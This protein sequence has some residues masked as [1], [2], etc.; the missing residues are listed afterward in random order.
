MK[1]YP[2]IIGI[3]LIGAVIC[4]CSYQTVA[5]A[6]YLPQ[7][8]YMPAAVNGI[9]TI[10]DIAPEYGPARYKIDLDARRLRIPLSL[11]RSG[12]KNERGITAVIEVNNDSVVSLIKNGE[13]TDKNDNTPELLPTAVMEIP[14]MIKIPDGAELGT[15]ELSVDLDFLMSHPKSRYVTGIKLNEAD[16]NISD[17]LRYMIIEINTRFIVPD[18]SFTCKVTDD[19]NYIVDFTNNSEY[20]IDYSW[21]FGDGTSAFSG[22]NPGSHQY[23]TTGNYVIT[24]SAHGIT[25]DVFKHV[26]NLKLWENITSLYISNSG[27]FKRKDSGGKTGLLADWLY[28]DNVAGSN[29]K[30]GFYLENGGVM[31]FY[32]STKALDNAKV[33][34]TFNLPKGSFRATFTPY[35]FKGVN[36]CYYVVA[37]GNCIPDIDRIENNSDVLGYFKWSDDIG[38]EPDGFEFTLDR[39]GE[40]TLGFVVSNEAKSR[41][42]ISNVSLYK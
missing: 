35:L 14:S 25:G 36:N 42:Q 21:D 10:D 8:I 29:G 4:S 18:V 3:L 15:F 24:L 31:D 13:L 16:C 33:Y 19:T 27:P 32:N 28:T 34:Q 41:V 9:Y 17:N 2:H 20:G 40:V 5:D 37:T 23:P 11:Y 7:Q 30:G 22:T 39:D 1:K 6:E 26:Y 12:I 38:K